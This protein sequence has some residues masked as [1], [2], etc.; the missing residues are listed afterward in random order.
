MAFRLGWTCTM[1]ASAWLYLFLQVVAETECPVGQAYDP[2]L[3]TC[4][5]VKMTTAGREQVDAE[6]T[7]EPPTPQGEAHWD[8]T[9]GTTQQTMTFTSDTGA[10]VHLIYLSLLIPVCGAIALGLFCFLRGRKNKA[11]NTTQP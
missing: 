7:P 6:T 10:Q 9:S 4:V 8:E 2:D 11:S 5:E 3:R 1:L